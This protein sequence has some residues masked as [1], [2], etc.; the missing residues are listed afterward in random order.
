MK[1]YL[2]LA[3][4]FLALVTAGLLLKKDVWGPSQPSEIGDQNYASV[5]IQMNET[6]FSPAKIT[7]K[8]GKAVKFINEGK[9]SH[10]PASNIHPTHAIYPEFDPK[11]GIAPGDSWSFIFDRV[12]SWRMHDHL[13]PRITGVIIVE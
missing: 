12:G 3:I 7:I 10:W 4:I 8:K 9:E 11:R 6:E 5:V 2:I 13:F 1:K